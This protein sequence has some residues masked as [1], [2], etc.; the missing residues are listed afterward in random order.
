M[1]MRLRVGANPAISKIT[2]HSTTGKSCKSME[3]DVRPR[4]ESAVIA[5]GIAAARL[6]AS[7]SSEEHVARWAVE[8][9][10]QLKL[11]YRDLTPKDALAKLETW[12]LVRYG[13]VLGPSVDQLRS[14]G[15]SWAEIIDAAARPGKH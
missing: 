2:M 15:K 14:A 13:N 4:Y 1:D 8:Q 11:S 6:L 5:L 12:T 9:R 3:H 7:G 10:N